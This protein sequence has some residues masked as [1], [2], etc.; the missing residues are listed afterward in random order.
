M[1]PINHAH[2]PRGKSEGRGGGGCGGEKILTRERRSETT[3]SGGASDSLPPP[4]PPP[5]PFRPLRALSDTPPAARV[6]EHAKRIRL[7]TGARV[8]RNR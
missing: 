6:R 3:S 1:A 5:P 4:P 8:C 2:E 7:S